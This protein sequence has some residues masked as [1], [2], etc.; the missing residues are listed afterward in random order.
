MRNSK[1]IAVRWA[2]ARG[3]GGRA[4]SRN[5]RPRE[6]KFSEKKNPRKKQHASLRAHTRVRLCD[7]TPA[8]MRLQRFSSRAAAAAAAALVERESL[9][10]SFGR[11][12]ARLSRERLS[13]LSRRRV[14]ETARLWNSANEA[15]RAGDNDEDWDEEQTPRAASQLAVYDREFDVTRVRERVETGVDAR[16]DDGGCCGEPRD[17]RF[18]VGILDRTR[19]GYLKRTVATSRFTKRKSKPGSATT[20]TPRSLPKP[21]NSSQQSARPPEPRERERAPPL[22]FRRKETSFRG[23]VRRVSRSL[24]RKRE[25]EKERARESRRLSLRCARV[26]AK[27]AL[28]DE[29]PP[30]RVSPRL[31]AHS[32][33][34]SPSETL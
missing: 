21:P 17:L 3:G 29:G 8:S 26:G 10:L 25:R 13:F 15:R 18:I 6:K 12:R 22:L 27:T 1:S 33:V 7:S 9:S 30:P 32:F 5:R 11:E 31:S 28:V 24:P 4:R 16:G 20:P 19:I 34:S 14:Q 2:Q 23:Q